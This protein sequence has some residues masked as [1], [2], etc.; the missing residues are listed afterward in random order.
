MSSWIGWREGHT[1]SSSRL[2]LEGERFSLVQHIGPLTSLGACVI[3]EYVVQMG[4]VL[5]IDYQ[6]MLHVCKS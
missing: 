5:A 3:V 4:G 6:I 1:E 2:P